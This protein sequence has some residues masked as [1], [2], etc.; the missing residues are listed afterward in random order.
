[1]RYIGSLIFLLLGSSIF[2]HGPVHELIIEYTEKIEQDPQNAQLYLQRGEYYRV[3]ENFDA[4]YADFSKAEMLDPSLH[5]NVRF[6][7]GHL[8]SEHGFP[9]SG[10]MNMDEFL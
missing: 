1:M 6:H 10:L 5:L 8:F 9:Q 7:L 2:A 4:A 3:D